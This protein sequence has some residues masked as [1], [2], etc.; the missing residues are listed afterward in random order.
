MSAV[1]TEMPVAVDCRL[2]TGGSTLR[3][4]W[5]IRFFSRSSAATYTF[6]AVPDG[7]NLRSMTYPVSLTGTFFTPQT[8]A[9]GVLASPAV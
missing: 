1:V 9:V 6:T 8:N 2:L 7:R 4:G 3:P 5:P